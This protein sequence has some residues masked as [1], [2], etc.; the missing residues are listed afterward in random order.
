MKFNQGGLKVVLLLSRWYESGLEKIG[1]YK[2]GLEVAW[3]WFMAKSLHDTPFQVG[4][5]TASGAAV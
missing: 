5:A 3:K 1:W 2:S 4:I